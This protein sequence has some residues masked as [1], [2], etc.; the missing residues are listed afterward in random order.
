VTPRV[1]SRGER[2]LQGHA[3]CTDPDEGP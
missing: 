2:S 3:G 1:V